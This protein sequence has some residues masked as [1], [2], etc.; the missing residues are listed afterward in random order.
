M[1]FADAS[2][3]NA[4][5]L[6]TCLDEAD[7]SGLLA[8]LGPLPARRIREAVSTLGTVSSSER[9]RVMRAFLL[10]REFAAASTNAQWT[11]AAPAGGV[12]LDE[13]LARRMA[14]ASGE[15]LNANPLAQKSAPPPPFAFLLETE[16]DVVA[17]FLA[18]ESPQTVAVV[19]SYLR[20]SQAAELLRRLDPP[21]QTQVLRRLA[22]L[23]DIDPSSIDVV[24]E[25]LQA[26]LAR[27]SDAVH[28]PG[29]IDGV[30]RDMLA[31]RRAHDR[32][33]VIAD[34]QREAG[35]TSPASLRKDQVCAP[36]NEVPPLPFS[37]VECRPRE[38][39][40]RL[41]FDDLADLSDDDL[42]RTIQSAPR[43]VLILALLGAD[44]EL[45]RRI[46][47]SVSRREAR[48][49]KRGLRIEGP[50][51]LGDIETAQRRIAQVATEIVYGSQ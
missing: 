45:V 7:A 34:L 4:A 24:A 8:V 5:V 30:L 36:K 31:G 35:R 20:R 1:A 6:V 40:P 43:D 3:R 25:E 42:L 2:L 28:E 21:L 23:D 29:K 14:L 46:T 9:E 41:E 22:R 17:P 15:D 13:G 10:G 37:H 38:P 50:T 19:L 32:A 48:Q 44:E 33:G 49:I 12:E 16:A 26:W 51:R 47:R 11:E 18:R 27:Q 39:Q